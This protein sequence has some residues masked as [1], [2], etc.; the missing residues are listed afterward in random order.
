MARSG[1]RDRDAHP[2]VARVAESWTETAGVSD[3]ADDIGKGWVGRV[4]EI[5]I[6]A[7]S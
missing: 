3:Q 5:R 1:L 2:A 4:G 6:G 7:I